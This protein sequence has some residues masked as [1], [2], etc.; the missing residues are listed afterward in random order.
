LMSLS[1]RNGMVNPLVILLMKRFAF[2][3]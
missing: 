3:G 2:Y 1:E